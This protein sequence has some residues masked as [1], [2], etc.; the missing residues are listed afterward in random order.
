VIH[1]DDDAHAEEID[2]E[3]AGD[4]PAE[5]LRFEHHRHPRPHASQSFANTRDDV[6]PS[7]VASGF[8]RT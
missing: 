6:Q 8:S 2:D 3:V 4:R 7:Y 1:E 5:A